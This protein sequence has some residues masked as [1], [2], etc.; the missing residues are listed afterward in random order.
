MFYV[1]E[2]LSRGG[3]GCKNLKEGSGRRRTFLLNFFYQKLAPKNTKVKRKVWWQEK[4][5][6]IREMKENSFPATSA[7]ILSLCI[8]FT[9]NITSG[10]WYLT[11]CGYYPQIITLLAPHVWYYLICGVDIIR[12]AAISN[13]QVSTIHHLLATNAFVDWG[14]KSCL[15]KYLFNVQFVYS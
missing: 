7:V 12:K 4:E 1:D 8:F 10:I 2:I 13:Q 6:L 3:F 11:I 14:K 9:D 5:V 15:P